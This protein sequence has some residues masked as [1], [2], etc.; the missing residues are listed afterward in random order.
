ME[1][2]VN[3][4]DKVSV[5]AGLFCGLLGRLRLCCVCARD[6]TKCLQKLFFFH[7]AN[8]AVDNLSVFNKEECGEGLNRE[9]VLYFVYAGFIDA[10]RSDF[11]VTVV[12]GDANESR[13]HHEARRATGR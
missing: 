5:L 12:L 7:D 4:A 3:F 8:E 2:T 13:N 9:R 6:V 11:D 10:D 1:L